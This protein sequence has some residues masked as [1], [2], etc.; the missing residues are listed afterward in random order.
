VSAVSSALFCSDL[1]AQGGDGPVVT[2]DDLVGV[3]IASEERSQS[4]SQTPATAPTLRRL[5]ELAPRMLAMMH[6]SSYAGNAAA[7]L[8]A[9][10]AH[11]AQK[12]NQASP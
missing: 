5:A 7:S 4:M 10:A 9:L 3:A 1:F 11:S 6:G 2:R 8:E 12:L